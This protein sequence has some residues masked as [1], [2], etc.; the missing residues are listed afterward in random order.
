MNY[1]ERIKNT[2]PLINACNAYG[3]AVN[4]AGFTKCVVHHEKTASMKLYDN[5]W[6]CFGCGAHGDIIDLVKALF[7]LD[8]MGAVRKLNDDFALNLP[9]ERQSTKQEREMSA[10]QAWKARKEREASESEK[11]RLEDEYFAAM[12]EVIMYEKYLRLYKPTEIVS[13]LHPLFVQALHGIEYAKHR[14]E[15]ADIRLNGFTKDRK[16]HG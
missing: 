14:L 1:T 3:I 15:E 5:K 16:L 12:D 2:V 7:S 9:L 4:H 8:Y 13:E 6:H 10:K 11:H